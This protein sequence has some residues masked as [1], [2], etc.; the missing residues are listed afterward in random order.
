MAA[1]AKSMSTHLEQLEKLNYDSEHDSSA[2]ATTVYQSSRLVTWITMAI[3]ALITLLLAWR[4][5]VSL[6]VPIGQALLASESV[7]S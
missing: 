3:S 5:T 1:I 7:S 6:F 2:R 4:L